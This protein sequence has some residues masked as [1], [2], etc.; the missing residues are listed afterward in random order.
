MFKKFRII[1]GE[2]FFIILAFI[3][4]MFISFTFINR[5]TK[6]YLITNAEN[7]LNN[8]ALKIEYTFQSPKNILNSFAATI[9]NIINNSCEEDDLYHI[10]E[11][12][13]IHMGSYFLFYNENII[14]PNGFFGYL[15]INDEFVH[16]T[17]R[18]YAYPVQDPSTR[19]WF[20]N[21]RNSDKVVKTLS[22]PDPLTNNFIIIYSINIFNRDD[23]W[24][25]VVALRV[26]MTQLEGT[27]KNIFVNENGY[28]TLVYKDSRTII[29]H[30][31]EFINKKFDEIETLAHIDFKIIIQE[32]I[33]YKKFVN[34][35]GESSY[36][37]I[38]KLY[39]DWFLTTIVPI[40]TFSRTSDNLIK[41]LITCCMIFSV[42]I[43]LILI[44]IEKERIKAQMENKYKSIFLANMNHEIRTPV[45]AIMGMS[46]IGQLSDNIEKK[47]Y[48]FE[49]IT[50]SS[51]Y[52]LDIINDILD[53]SKIEANK[54]ELYPHEFIFKQM[55]QRIININQNR[56]SDKKQILEIDIDE[57]I[58][59][60]IGD[61]Q[62]ISQVIL[63]LLSNAIKFTPN[64]GKITI[65][66]KLLSKENDLCVIQTS[67]S[68]TG[69]GLTDDQKGKLFKSFHQADKD[70]YKKFGGT[71]LGL[72]I[73]KHIIE[74]MN[75]VI[76]VESEP[77]KGSTFIFIVKMKEGNPDNIIEK[78]EEI[79]NVNL[80]KSRIL[81]VEDIEINR[82][83]IATLL[84]PTGVKIDMAENG[85]I[86]IDMFINDPE[87]YNLILM[88][89][90]MPE[91]DGLTATKI[92]RKLDINKAKTIPI[93]AMT[94]N[95]FK[96]N[97]TECLEAGMNDHLGKPI[98]LAEVIKKLKL[99]LLI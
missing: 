94:A 99:Y 77:K 20:I 22:F 7:V 69:I 59:V 41:I 45:N 86:A 30:R 65:S 37:F 36:I 27:V 91:V 18:G 24:L 35:R 2:I 46:T 95:V 50:K 64:E 56:I 79:L 78:R 38:K 1:I 44:K 54:L 66:A 13:M 34:Y 6:E 49:N 15:Y 53:I 63:N 42:I 61:E 87:R 16:I 47:D 17:G 51:E 70:T 60:L 57:N 74:M 62:R 93:I 31:D 39:N 85:Q 48:C 83:I 84:E 96:E 89:V 9:E 52:L 55:I 19:E 26:D 67:V 12:Y 8:A 76:W 90:H 21:A 4:M 82:E 97:I 5:T 68:D 10:I 92:I 88:D 43:I 33:F 98:D 75:G 32:R 58:P 28:S 80:E 81:I 72:A 73:S 23:E 25:G 14:T 29:H 71:G 11:N 40:K 3:L